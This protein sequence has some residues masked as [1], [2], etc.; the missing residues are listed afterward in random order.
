MLNFVYSNLTLYNVMWISCCN[1][2]RR[3]HYDLAPCFTPALSPNMNETRSDIKGVFAVGSGIAALVVVTLLIVVPV[4]C[5][6]IKWYQRQRE[7]VI[8]NPVTYGRYVCK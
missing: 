5:V 8:S 6:L 3:T 1:G 7:M 4:V 2:K